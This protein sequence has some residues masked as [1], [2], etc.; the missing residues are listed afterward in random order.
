MGVEG[1]A[2]WV[3]L[4]DPDEFW[5][6]SRGLIG[7]PSKNVNVLFKEFYQLFS[8]LIRQLGSNLKEL[9]RIVPYNNLYKIFT[10][11]ILGWLIDG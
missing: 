4:T 3:Q 9:F 5:I 2:S 1:A 7:I 10:L 8:L 11:C 6:Y